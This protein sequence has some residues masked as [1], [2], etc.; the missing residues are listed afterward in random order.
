[1]SDN[2]S[3]AND[4]YSCRPVAVLTARARLRLVANGGH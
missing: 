4:N 1:M 3:Q 2:Y